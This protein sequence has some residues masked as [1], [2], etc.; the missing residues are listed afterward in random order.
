MA[1]LQVTMLLVYFRDRVLAANGS[2]IFYNSLAR[3]EALIFS[4]IFLHAA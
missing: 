3:S 4:D 1:K 2:L